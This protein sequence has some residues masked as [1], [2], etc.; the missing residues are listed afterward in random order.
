M[1]TSKHFAPA[2]FERCVPSCSIDQMDQ[3]FLDRLD[4][5]REK[6]GIPL[7]LNCAFRSKEWDRS[8]GRSGNSA[9]T[10]GRAVDIRCNAD[11]TRMK[12]VKAA[13]E[14]G[15]TRVGIEGRFIHVD[16]SPSLSQGAMWVY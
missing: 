1:K 2:E 14:L 11:A 13:L 10:E 7:L 12:I 3:A 6:A 4:Q 8:K 16:T 5:L 15:F 9:H